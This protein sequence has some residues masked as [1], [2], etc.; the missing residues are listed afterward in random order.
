[1]RQK[2]SPQSTLQEA[3]LEFTKEELSAFLNFLQGQKMP[4]CHPNS[5]KATTTTSITEY[6]T[7]S[8]TTTEDRT[9]TTTNSSS[10]D[11]HATTI[12]S[13]GRVYPL[14]CHPP[15]CRFR[16]VARV[17]SRLWLFGVGIHQTNHQSSPSQSLTPQEFITV[18]IIQPPFISLH[19][20]VDPCV[21]P[22]NHLIFRTGTQVRVH[23]RRA[24]SIFEFST[25]TEN[26]LMSS[27]FFK[28]RYNYYYRV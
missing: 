2:A 8:S 21:P 20:S 16:E 12:D 14:H 11:H 24:L 9:T 19:F 28:G 25:R 5:S 13:R 27:Q 6:S 17:W 26:A 3:V 15:T 4:S 22:I 1:M 7:T 23:K 10:D 18:S